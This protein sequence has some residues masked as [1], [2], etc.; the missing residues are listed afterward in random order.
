MEQDAVIFAGSN[1]YWGG[2]RGPLGS[3]TPPG[4]YGNCMVEGE[5]SCPGMLVGCDFTFFGCF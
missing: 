3:C 2:S 1:L 4:G 5:M